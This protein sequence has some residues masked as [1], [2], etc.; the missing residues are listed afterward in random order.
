MRA[1]SSMD[2]SGSRRR[3][4]VTRSRARVRVRLAPAP[5]PS[6]GA[7]DD[8]Q[9]PPAA[10]PANDSK[11]LPQVIG[12]QVGV[13]HDDRVEAIDQVSLGRDGQA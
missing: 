10:S 8:H 13:A 5:R 4:S 7:G 1:G 11:S 3:R 2:G 6:P 12:R 9:R